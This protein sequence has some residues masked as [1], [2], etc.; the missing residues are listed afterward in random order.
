[1]SSSDFN[2]RTALVTGSATGLG[3]ELSLML[4]EAGANVVINART[5]GDLVDETVE[6]VT[7]AGGKAIGVLADVADPDQVDELARRT[8]EAFGG[9]DIL[10][11]SA[12]FRPTANVLELDYDEWRKVLSVKLDGAFLCSRAFLP[13]MIERNHGR[14]INISGLDAFFGSSKKLHVG[15]ANLGLVGMTRGLA[16]EFSQH[17]ITVNTVAPG[18]IGVAR[19]QHEGDGAAGRDLDALANSFPARRVGLPNEIAA[20]CKFLASDEASYVTGQTIH[21]NGGAYPT[22]GWP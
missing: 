12:G 6:A 22:R 10:V 16:V 17:G 19:P 18:V 1:M 3:R 7:A 14:I 15:T 9:V 21:V 20:V 4:A 8:N 11:N 13:G 2:G 5:S